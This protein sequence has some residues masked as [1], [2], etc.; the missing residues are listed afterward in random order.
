MVLPHLV[1]LYLDWPLSR[2]GRAVALELSLRRRF[3][4]CVEV[5]DLRCRRGSAYMDFSNKAL[6]HLVYL[7]IDRVFLV[8][9][10]WWRWN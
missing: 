1:R 4:G 8:L 2:T 5:L 10:G 7:C 3:Y 9:D 6:R